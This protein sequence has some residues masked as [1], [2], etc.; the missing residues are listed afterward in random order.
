MSALTKVGRVMRRLLLLIVFLISG[1]CSSCKGQNIVANAKSDTSTMD[2]ILQDSYSGAVAEEV[3]VIK[4]QKS[5]ESFFS[6]INKTRKPGLPV[7]QIDFDTDMLFVWCEGE[8]TAA[9]LGLVLQKE[10]SESYIISKLNPKI[11]SNNTAITSPFKVYKL[12]LS[13]KEITIR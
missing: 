4:S 2:L 5:L 11:K 12:P 7:P 10:T 9:S 13:D 8:T 1:L 3:I 6:K